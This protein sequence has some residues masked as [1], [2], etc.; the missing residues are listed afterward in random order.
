MIRS[1]F[2]FCLLY[3]FKDF[4]FVS[5]QTRKYQNKSCG[6]KT[7]SRARSSG[8][9]IHP[10]STVTPSLLFLQSKHLL[11]LASSMFRQ[12]MLSCHSAPSLLITPANLQLAILPIYIVFNY[13]FRK[14]LSLN[15]SSSRPWHIYTGL[16][17]FT[18]LSMYDFVLSKLT[19]P[20]TELYTGI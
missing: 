17:Y 7:D 19:L 3:Q 16:Y 13:Y 15:T 9:P 5:R 20:I 11:N 8:R 14:C 4:P 2:D 6:N 12:C 1:Q 18:Y 10:S